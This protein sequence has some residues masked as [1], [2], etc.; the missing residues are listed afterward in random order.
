MRITSFE[1]SSRKTPMLSVSPTTV[2]RSVSL[3]RSGS[4]GGGGLGVGGGGEE[5]ATGGDRGR[6]DGEK[7][8]RARV[9]ASASTGTAH[10]GLPRNEVSVLA[11]RGIGAGSTGIS[12]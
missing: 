2:P 7:I 11:G 8:G 3:R 5:A 1:V 4:R 9:S 10:K 12:P 6:R